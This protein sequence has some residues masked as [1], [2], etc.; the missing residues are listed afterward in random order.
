MNESAGAVR[1]AIFDILGREVI[2]PV[3]EYRDAGSVVVS[4]E[5][6]DLPAVVYFYTV[7][8][9]SGKFSGK[10]VRAE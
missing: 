7:V 1:V 9:A 2:R 6:G 8:T 3:D 4:V 10:M 5:S